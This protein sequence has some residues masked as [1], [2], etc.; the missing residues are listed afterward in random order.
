MAYGLPYKGSKQAICKWLFKNFPTADNFY[1]LFG[2]GGSCTHFACLTG[3]Y[4]NIYYNELNRNIYQG[5]KDAIAGKYLTRKEWI[6]RETFFLN[7]GKGDLYNDYVFSF[8][9]TGETYICAK[10][11]EELTKAIFIGTMHQNYR[12][13]E[14]IKKITVPSITPA[15]FRRLLNDYNLRDTI[16]TNVNRINRLTALQPYEI[17][18]S[19]LSYDEVVIKPNSI[20]YCDLPY[21]GT[22]GYEFNFDYQKFYKW[23]NRQNE[24]VF[25]SEYSMPED[26]FICI[27]TIKKNTTLKFDNTAKTTEKL[28]IPKTQEELWKQ[29]VITLF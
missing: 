29:K 24:L 11:K 23:A 2:G 3:N 25:I 14:K 9:C 26:L 22:S 21:F 28:F 13:F 4:K 7:R 27:A 18:F 12:L 16:N 19:N 8:N 1:D 5:F 10:D 20:I 17:N 15:G 6:D